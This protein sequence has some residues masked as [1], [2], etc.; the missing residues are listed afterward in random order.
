MNR[1]DEVMVTPLGGVMG[2]EL[3]GLDLCHPLSMDVVARV[4]GALLDHCVVVIR[5]Q[6]LSEDGQVRFSARFGRPI[7][8]V[9]PAAHRERPEVFVISNIVR[10]GMP[11]GALGHRALRYHSDLSFLREP[12]AISIL[13]AVQVPSTGGDTMWASGYAAYDALSPTLKRSVDGRWA[14]HR[15]WQADLNPAEPTHHPVVRTHPETG[16]KA[17]FISPDYTVSIDRLPADESRR[18]LD[19]L[20]EHMTRAE[21]VWRHRWRVGDVVM[22][23]NRCTI[24]R[25]DAFDGGQARLLHR[26][27]L[28]GDQPF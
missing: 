15:H 21:F 19:V 26:T 4:R 3:S 24:H 2:A 12:A 11:I 18:L 25:R 10:D 20:F 5:D 22:W 14:L 7:M 23:D 17:L 1:L 27:Q 16:R 8:D 9:R 6:S 13:H 28:A